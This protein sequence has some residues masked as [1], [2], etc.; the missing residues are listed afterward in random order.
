M[1]NGRIKQVN[2][3]TSTYDIEALYFGN[4]SASEW[5]G[6]IHGV[7][8]T[9]V[10]PAQ[11]SGTSDYKA[12]VESSAAQCSTTVS[13][14]NTLTGSTTTNTYKVGDII[15]MGATSDG[16]INFDRWISKISGTTVYLDVLETQVAT[17]HHTI[18]RT[19]ANALTGVSA[20]S[21]TSNMMAK[22]GSSVTV[23]KGGTGSVI[24]SISQGDGSS[25][26]SIATGTSTD[27]VGHSHTVKSHTHDVSFN[28]NS[29]VS[30]KAN[31]IETLT[32]A[33]YTP[34][35]HGNDVTAAGS[36]SDSTPFDYVY[37]GGKETFI[38]SLKDSSLTTSSTS[39]TTDE[40]T[41]GLSTSTIA[42]T[43]KTTTVESHVHSVSATTT[44]KVAKSVTLAAN[45][46]VSVALNFSAPTVQTNVVTAVTYTSTNVVSSVT[47]SSADFFSGCSVDADGVLSFISSKTI[48]SV[49]YATNTVASKL[50]VTNNNQ[51]AGSAS[52][53]VAS[54]A[55]TYV[56]GTVTATCNTGAAG[57]HSHGFSHNHTISAHT[58]TIASHTHTYNKSVKDATG[59]AYTS[60]SVSSYTPHVHSDDVTAAGS[61]SNDTKITY[62][63]EGSSTSVVKDL[64][65]TTKTFTATS[66]TAETDTQYYKLTGKITHPS[67][68][69]VS[70]ELVTLLSTTN[71]TPAES[72]NEYPLKDITFTSAGFINSV[73]EKTSEN[74]GGN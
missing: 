31:V 23:V 71:I 39:L 52:L 1:D 15:L 13:K 51:S 14:L 19:S 67:L 4:R 45:P 7:V 40:N 28:P 32:S 5:E 69:F 50:T 8:D 33:D 27:G 46:L 10:I 63:K 72:S 2:T 58:H 42:S 20:S 22:V 48:T 21:T 17:H 49:S 65:D 26:L 56:S 61:K 68:T 66:S 44:E 64:V 53:T 25:S 30:G 38:T 74:K 57:E 6:L 43:E 54:A 60:L 11:T 35:K 59:S 9:Y 29:F 36:T 34:H 62:I 37:G 70:T 16:K 47:T 24:T 55:Q 73:T 12:V 18:T 41:G 3:G